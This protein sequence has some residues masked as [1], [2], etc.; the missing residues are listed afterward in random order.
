VK[1]H[2]EE[3]LKSEILV[4]VIAPITIN[5]FIRHI[6]SKNVSCLIFD[7]KVFR[8]LLI[9]VPILSKTSFLYKL[10]SFFVK[11]TLVKKTNNI[12]LK[13]NLFLFEF[14][15]S[16]AIALNKNKFDVFY[17]KF[18]IQG[19][20]VAT[21][22]AK[23]FNALSFIDLGE[24]MEWL[25]D[26]YINNSILIQK[27]VQNTNGF[28]CVS[29][30]QIPWI[31]QFNFDLKNIHCYPNTVNDRFR[32]ISQYQCRAQ[33]N[34]PQNLFI[35]IFVGHFDNRKG[36]MRL[37]F[38]IDLIENEI[39]VIFVGSG[40]LKPVGDKVLFVGNIANEELPKWLNA[41]DVLVAP[42]LAEGNSNAINEA[43]ACGLP[44]ITS[45]ITENK[46]YF[47]S[48]GTIFVDPLNINEIATAIKM[49]QKNIT[50]RK[51]LSA[52]NLEFS[53]EMNKKSRAQKILEALKL[54]M[55]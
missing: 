29:D 11:E 31:S 47:A 23:K 41:A 50:L 6:F 25:N 7:E 39:G 15:C 22:F 27:I 1:K 45:N 49:L 55:N 14:S 35:V 9:Q 32:P 4:N 17:G 36:S 51:Q 26:L 54:H 8:P 2:V 38:A 10:I 24:N 21:R 37:K 48:S 28:F 42:T 44:I 53:K 34:L 33:L 18:I 12:L 13:F 30:T 3:W 5:D 43:I 52:L 16:Y 46:S 20:K 40:N 19:G